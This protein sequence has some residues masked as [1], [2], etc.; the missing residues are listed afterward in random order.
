[1]IVSE[2]IGKL[3]LLPQGAVVI[4]HGYEAGYNEA[5]NIEECLIVP[6]DYVHYGHAEEEGLPYYYGE[7]DL[8]EDGNG[9]DAV[10]ICSL[11]DYKC[12]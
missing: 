2:L 5:D 11:R 9:K 4:I 10:R 12:E 1:M 3:K 7:Y 8:G 6:F